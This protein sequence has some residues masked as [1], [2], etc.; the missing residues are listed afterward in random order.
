MADINLI[1]PGI[2][3]ATRVMLRRRPQLLLLRDPDAPAV[4]HL[5]R[6]AEEKDIAIE[7]DA[8]L[9]Y[10]AAALIQDLRHA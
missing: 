8:C 5:L 7:T 6:L 1:K 2:G 4:R 10:Q 9:P 3:E